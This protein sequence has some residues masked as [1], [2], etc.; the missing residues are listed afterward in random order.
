MTRLTV[1]HSTIANNA[2]T[3]IDVTR[4]SGVQQLSITD[5]TFT[6]NGSA[7][8]LAL[9]NPTTLILSGNSG[10][11][12]VSNGI[13]LSGSIGQNTTLPLNPGLTYVLANSTLT[14]ASGATL[15]LTEGVVVKGRSTNSAI[16]VNGALA[17]QGTAA[18]P[19]I[20]TSYKDDTVGGDT[21]GDGTASAPAK[22]DWEQ[23]YVGSTGTLTMTYATLRYGGNTI[24]SYDAALALLDNA[25]ATLDHVT[26]ADSANAGIYAYADTCWQRH[27]AHRHPRHH[28]Q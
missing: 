19:V 7:A 1:T 20:F 15:T 12:N 28:H 9:A 5:N 13:E 6:G 25:A 8:S 21:N 23:I 26:I 24:A 10:A 18:N 4:T 27:Q 3:G 16:A 22:G 17:M 14:V 2:A 11:G